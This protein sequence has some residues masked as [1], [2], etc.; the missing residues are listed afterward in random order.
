MAAA[1]SGAPSA[2]A[3]AALRPA[4]D[5]CVLPVRSTSIL[6]TRYSVPDTPYQHSMLFYELLLVLCGYRYLYGVFPQDSAWLE[7]PRPSSFWRILPWTWG[8]P[9]TSGCPARSLTGALAYSAGT[10]TEYE[11]GVQDPIYMYGVLYLVL[12]PSTSKTST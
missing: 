1:I 5:G 12:V 6:R 8:I 7:G 10:C 2:I 9:A 4:G 3:A 11:Y